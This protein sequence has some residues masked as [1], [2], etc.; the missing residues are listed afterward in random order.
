MFSDGGRVYLGSTAG[1]RVIPSGG[2]M[3][4]FKYRQMN[5][6]IL[7]FRTYC[8]ETKHMVRAYCM[9]GQGFLRWSLLPASYASTFSKKEERLQHNILRDM[10]GVMEVI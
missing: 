5:E 8:D 9:R 3:I 6:R 4:F 7:E 1:E 10:Y 2:V